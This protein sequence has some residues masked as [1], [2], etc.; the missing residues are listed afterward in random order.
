VLG[1]GS[2]I[3]NKYRLVRLVG[4][5]G[6][7]SVFEAEHTVLGS[8]VAIKVLHPELGRRSGLAE[9]FVQEAK[10][11]AQ[12]RSAHVV[13]VADVDRTPDGQAYIVMDLLE[14]E[15]LSAVL[16]RQGRLPL[17]TACDYTEQ[18]LEALEAAHALGVI[19]RDLKPE[20][21]F[22]TQEG[23]KPVLKLIDFGIAKAR[24][25]E[26]DR[27]LT[28]AGALM[29]TAEYMAPEQARSAA[30]VDA[31]ADIY[32]VGVML[33]EMI[34]GSRPATGE[35]ARVV[36]YKVERGE[37]VPLRHA[38]P[39]APREIA[40]LVHHAMA[41]RP[42]MR[43]ASATQMRAALHAARAGKASTPP[44]E[45]AGHTLRAMP[46]VSALGPVPSAP[47]LPALAVQAGG[48]APGAEVRAPEG[49]RRT[50]AVVALLLVLVGGGVGVAVAFQSG[51]LGP[52]SSG[53][54][55]APASPPATP[56][57]VD[58]SAATAT[59][60]SSAPPPA[61]AAV[62]PALQPTRPGPGVPG[63]ARPSA[64]AG[65]G[66]HAQPAEPFIPGFPTA[67]PGFPSAIPFPT[68]LP[69]GFPTALPSTLP[70]G[71]P[72]ILPPWPMAPSPAAPSPSAAP[73]PSAAPTP[74]A[75]PANSGTI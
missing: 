54:S 55:V 61:S 6:M 14:G 1:I 30:N 44:S 71:F 52:A 70:S 3:G 28:V 15:P 32:A 26:G 10:V 72:T 41:P 17:A 64:A 33:Y 59:G 48:T 39:D 36:A 56:P 50:W 24:R 73:A 5:G 68:A 12:I 16:S 21:V 53:P 29:G 7:G 66:G 27:H 42:D 67:L 19:H 46:V 63:S 75:A 22:V 74:S 11:A 69:S 34:A 35:D 37:V 13:R 4:E 49:R 40:G 2:V 9:R 25:G 38:A 47:V 60:S 62:V 51:M 45:P 20:N 65:D 57:A 8:R 43:F 23:G 18:I 31:R 58:L